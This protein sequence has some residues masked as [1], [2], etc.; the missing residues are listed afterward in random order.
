[1]W[2]ICLII[3]RNEPNI[4]RE[5][6]GFH[7]FATHGNFSVLNKKATLKQKAKKTMVI[8]I[9]RVGTK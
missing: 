8:A 5:S 9:H 3:C 2:F 1:M 4:K 6:A 7:H